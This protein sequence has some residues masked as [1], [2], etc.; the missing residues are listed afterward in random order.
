MATE[1]GLVI[2]YEIKATVVLEDETAPKQVDGISIVPPSSHFWVEPRGS[3]PLL[4][5]FEAGVGE[6]RFGA[7]LTLDEDSGDSEEQWGTVEPSAALQ[8]RV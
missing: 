8:F 3:T 6:K 5:L 1:L 4:F 2:P 7:T